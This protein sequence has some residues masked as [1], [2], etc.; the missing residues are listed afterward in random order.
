MQGLFDP[1]GARLI[2]F[3]RSAEGILHI[4]ILDK[5]SN[6]M[7]GI[8]RHFDHP[9]TMGARH[10]EDIVRLLDHF[11]GQGFG[12]MVGQI[13][14]PVSHRPA[15]VVRSASISTGGTSRVDHDA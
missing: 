6:P 13:H 1:R 11:S 15:G 9:I 4:F 3:L 12:L 10:H 14:T 7:S 8:G 2:L 5:Q